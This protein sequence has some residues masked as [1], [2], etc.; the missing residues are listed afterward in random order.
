M[1][2]RSPRVESTFVRPTA[3]QIENLEAAA[4]TATD[5]DNLAATV[6]TFALP[7]VKAPKEP[8]PIKAAKEP[9]QSGPTIRLR[10]F[11]L[12]AK[13]PKGLSGGQIK[14]QLGLGGVPSILKDE[15]FGTTPRIRRKTV[16]GSRAVTYEL[17]PAGREAVKKGKV[18][19]G[20]APSSSGQEIPEGR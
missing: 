3:A 16:E 1:A 19:D 13:A 7:A 10:V 11:Q 14:E 2:I 8:K 20:A 9:K 17:T 18:D 6:T 12:L 4:S 15:L 5:L